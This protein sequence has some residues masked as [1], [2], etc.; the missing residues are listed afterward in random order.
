MNQSEHRTYYTDLFIPFF[1]GT[2]MSRLS[3]LALNRIESKGFIRYDDYHTPEEFCDV[4]GDIPEIAELCSDCVIG[5]SPLLM[6]LPPGFAMDIHRDVNFLDRRKSNIS[7]IVLPQEDIA[8]TLF[9]DG[10][11]PEQL[12]LSADWSAGN[13][14]LLNIQEWHNVENNGTWR[15]NLQLSMDRYYDEVLDLIGQGKLFRDFECELATPVR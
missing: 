14:R 6:F 8:P 3:A 1:D 15:A 5:C 10:P 11:S 4:T 12:V 7:I 2:M 13:P 9:Y